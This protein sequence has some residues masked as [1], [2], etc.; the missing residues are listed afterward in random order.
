M[1]KVKLELEKV[2]KIYQRLLGIDFPVWKL[3]REL[4][5]YKI[6]MD[7][8]S[9]RTQALL[10]KYD[11]KVDEILQKYNLDTDDYIEIKNDLDEKI[12]WSKYKI[13]EYIDS[14]I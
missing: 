7:N 6:H 4:Y 12:D 2:D 13:E 11:E 9:I 1:D 5:V 10:D 14:I 8:L 3:G